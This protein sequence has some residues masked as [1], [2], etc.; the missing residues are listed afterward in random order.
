[1]TKM[2][3]KA[4]GKDV[5]KKEANT[6]VA[7]YDYGDD[8]G[9]GF[10]D[11]GRESF[12]VPFLYLLQPNSPIIAK[13][14]N[15]DAKPGMIM[16]TVDQS[17]FPAIKVKD[18]QGILFVPCYHE[19]WFVEWKPIDAGGGFIGQHAP[20]SQLVLDMKHS[21]QPFGK[22]KTPEGNELVDT[23]YLYGEHLREDG[24]C[25]PAII[26]F[27][28]TKIKVYRQWMTRARS[29]R[30][31]TANGSKITPPL[32]AHVWRIQTLQQ[33]KDTHTFYNFEVGFSGDN[34][35]E[36]RLAPDNP[37]FV[38]AKEFYELC[39]EGSVKAATDSLHREAGEDD[40]SE[41]KEIP[42]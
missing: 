22:W 12:A 29:L 4:A 3:R 24:D 30:I 15:E 26:A 39:K 40:V 19:H 32:W 2:P 10:E 31:L 36:S 33:T 16:N 11:M 27:N 37:I 23:F 21:N 6:G 38:A 41:G 9:A 14:E 18:Q 42:F 35:V 1:M 20:D 5:A 8:A 17:L 28:S 7:I 13:G 25:S 34:A